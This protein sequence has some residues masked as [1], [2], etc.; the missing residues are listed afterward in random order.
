M[1][2]TIFGFRNYDDDDDVQDSKFQ[3]LPSGS[4]KGTRPPPLL[5]APTLPPVFF[6]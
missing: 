1:I 5:T 6:V 3:N 2:M 4:G